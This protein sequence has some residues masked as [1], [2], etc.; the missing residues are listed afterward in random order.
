MTLVR[1]AGIY[2]YQV[3]PYS[4]KGGNF[5]VSLAMWRRH[6]IFSRVFVME[7]STRKVIRVCLNRI[8]GN[9]LDSEQIVLNSFKE[10]CYKYIRETE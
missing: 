1:L 2:L 8:E 4:S 9:T 5:P 6:F 3:Y 7:L 10:C